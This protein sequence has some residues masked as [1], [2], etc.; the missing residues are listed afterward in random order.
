MS[1]PTT[2][3]SRS[4]FSVQALRQ[5]SRHARLAAADELV[6]LAAA[7]GF[8]YLSDHGV[9]PN[10]I[11]EAYEQA[12]TYFART[13]E[14]KL[15]DYIGAGSAHRGYVPVSEQGLYADEGPRLYEAFDVGVAKALTVDDELNPL[16]GENTWPDQNGFEVVITRYIQEMR[17]LA[18]V[19][20][21]GFEIGLGVERHTFRRHMSNPVSQ[22]RLLHYLPNSWSDR[23]PVNMGAHTDYELFTIVHSDREGLQ[24]LDQFETWID[25]PPVDGM[26]AFNIGD[27]FEAWT[28]GLLRATPHR[29]G[30]NGVERYSFAF[31]AATDFDTVIAPV[32]V[33]RF[34]DVQTRIPPT[35]PANISSNNYYGI[36]PIYGSGLSADSCRCS[37]P[38]RLSP[39]TRIRSSLEFT[40]AV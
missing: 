33:P 12:S 9:D 1:R 21:D 23:T 39:T 14:Q 30:N 8:L 35:V 10:L 38:K 31:F 6:E 20:T 22:L 19:I 15:I 17:R 4:V 37:I 24:I 2:S 13:D 16:L 11:D 25:V 36:S 27:M 29:V 3:T 28:G 40:E 18:D 5:G 7:S 34:P 26:F 32:P